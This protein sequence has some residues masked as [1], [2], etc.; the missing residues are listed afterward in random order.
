MIDMIDLRK[1]ER[2]AAEV[3]WIG[4]DILF[5]VCEMFVVVVGLIVGGE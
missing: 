3:V 5:E 4:G 1:E 2:G